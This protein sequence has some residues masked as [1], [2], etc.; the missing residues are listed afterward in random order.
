[1]SSIEASTYMRHM[2]IKNAAI[3]LGI[4]WHTLYTRLKNQGVAMRSDKL[5]YGSDRDKLGALAE[6]L[7]K[8][9]V[10]FAQDRNDVEYQAKYDFDVGDMKVD[11]KSSKPR[12]LSKKFAAKSWSF[13][14]KKQSHYCDFFVCFCCEDDATVSKILLVP[15]EF[16]VGLQTISVSRNGS[17]K[18]LEYSIE[19][20]ELGG[21][22]SSLMEGSQ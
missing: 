22:F 2:N 5:K 16:F 1:M 19:P 14:F 21:F 12:Q 10:P 8:E 20:H 4:S 3:E 11:V 9:M 13:S 6:R 17:S 18:W 7:F 15:K